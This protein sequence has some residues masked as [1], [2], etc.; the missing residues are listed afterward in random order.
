MGG[1]PTE[2]SWT[3]KAGAV[4]VGGSRRE[5]SWAVALRQRHHRARPAVPI[6]HPRRWCMGRRAGW[7][8]RAAMGGVINELDRPPDREELEADGRR[9][10]GV[11]G[12]LAATMFAPLIRPV[13]GIALTTRPDCTSISNAAQAKICGSVDKAMAMYDDVSSGGTAYC[14]LGSTSHAATG[15]TSTSSDRR[16][17]P[18]IEPAS[19]P[20]CSPLPAVEG[21]ASPPSPPAA[22]VPTVPAPLLCWRAPRGEKRERGERRGGRERGW[23]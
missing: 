9:F 11:I 6:P 5:R 1:R 3:R 8:V 23:C 4:G 17:T 13:G 7:S 15:S 2:R 19:S 21:C 14:S 16:P 18:P 20:L 10:S 12:W 22:G